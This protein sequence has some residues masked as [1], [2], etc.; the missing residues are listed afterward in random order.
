MSHGDLPQGPVSTAG[1]L[2]VALVTGASRG[3][4]AVI[5]RTLASDGW[6][7]AVNYRSDSA[8]AADVAEGIVAEGGRAAAVR[9]DV[10]DAEAVRDG[11][12]AIRDALGPVDLVVN[13]A[14][15]PQPV[16]P[17]P[18]QEWED[19]DL[20]LAFFVR[21]P[22][23]LLQGCLADWR[24][25]GSGRIVS[26]GSEVA[27][28]GP[29]AFAHYA[30]AKSAMIGLTRSWATE[31]GPDGITVNLV[32]PGFTPVERH[33]SV[34]TAELDEYRAGVPLGRM[35]RAVDIAGTVAFLASPRAD[36]ITGQRLPVNGGRTFG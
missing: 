24:A 28:T 20:Q 22:F 26:I 12:A 16:K 14:T 5:A 2:K 3:L 17:L 6:A 29:A 4:G 11:L 18:E 32:E 36:F 15:G 33:A 34:A 25:R 23:L 13:N 21:A 9:F 19:Y 1:A 8:G 27:T 7:V 10:T 35:A 31:L 30:A